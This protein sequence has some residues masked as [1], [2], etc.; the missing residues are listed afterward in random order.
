MRVH[1][2]ILAAISNYFATIL[3]PKLVRESGNE[4]VLTDLDGT[5]LK[6]LVAYFYTGNIDIPAKNLKQ[7]MDVASK[8]E[9]KLL[10]KKC[11]ECQNVQ[12]SIENCIDWL[13][14]GQSRRA[15]QCTPNNK[16]ALQG[17]TNARVT[18]A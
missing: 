14:F 15:R 13:M 4:I 2:V 5:L 11:A 18:E 7:F 10:Q 16:Q 8:F 9:F 3:G 1:R 12:F 6:D 17:H